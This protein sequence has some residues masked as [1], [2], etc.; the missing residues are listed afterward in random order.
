MFKSHFIQLSFPDFV[1][2]C[3]EEPSQDVRAR[4]RFGFLKMEPILFH[5]HD[6]GDSTNICRGRD[7]YE[8]KVVWTDVC[9]SS[10]LVTVFVFVFVCGSIAHKCVSLSEDFIP[11]QSAH[12]CFFLSMFFLLS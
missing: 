6:F 10:V 5:M 8:C 2:R 4:A 7:F 9:I 1:V 12:K 11:F 3:A